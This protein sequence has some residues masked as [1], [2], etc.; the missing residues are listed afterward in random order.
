MKNGQSVKKKIGRMVIAAFLLMAACGSPHSEEQDNRL[1]VTILPQRQILKRIAGDRF[2]V[3]VIIPPG[4]NPA[5]YSPAP[6]Q[7]RRLS[8]TRIWFRIGRLPFELHWLPR[9]ASANPALSIVDTS[10]GTDWITPK[11]KGAG[12]GAGVDPHIWLSPRLAKI[13]AGHMA[14]ALIRMDPENAEAYNEGYHALVREM[15]DLDARIRSILKNL[16]SRNFLVFHPSWGYFARDYGLVQ[17]AIEKEGKGPAPA[18]LAETVTL[19]RRE[20]LRVVFVQRQ[21]DTTAAEVV[22]REIGGRVVKLDP[23]AEDWFK[24]LEETA[25]MLGNALREDSP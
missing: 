5:T 11:R 22:A 18:S 9:I 6:G 19:A 3:D 25:I 8:R 17:V 12:G 16:T 10:E 2:D 21:F 13:Q 1:A 15:D 7:I 20:G 24:N 4:F 23:L 14:E